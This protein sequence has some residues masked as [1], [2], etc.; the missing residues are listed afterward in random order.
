MRLGVCASPFFP[1]LLPRCVYLY[2]NYTGMLSCIAALFSRNAERARE[3][4][5]CITRH[6]DRSANP[7][8]LTPEGRGPLNA[9][10]RHCPVHF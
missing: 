9:P 5:S 6:D 8:P 10:V 7:A 4:P 1:V 3:G 2:V